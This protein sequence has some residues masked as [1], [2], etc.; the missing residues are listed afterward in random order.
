M[1]SSGL[2]FLIP[3]LFFCQ[4]LCAWEISQYPRAYIDRQFLRSAEEF[5]WRWEKYASDLV[6]SLWD[7]DRSEAEV[8]EEF[9]QLKALRFSIWYTQPEQWVD[10]IEVNEDFL[11]ADQLFFADR[12]RAGNCLAFAYNNT[13][14]IYNSSN[15]I[16]GSDRFLAMEGP[17][18]VLEE[19]FFR[20]LVTYQVS[21]LVRLTPAFETR[22]KCHS[23][24]KGR[25][26]MNDK[27]E[28]TLLV[29]MRGGADYLLRYYEVEN[30][31]D[32]HGMDPE[33]L[34]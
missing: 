5:D 16:I 29:P 11:F 28:T 4:T 8:C 10:Y 33:V 15:I 25:T 32:H 14:P 20:L 31:R 26:K 17:R 27:G 12:F 23:Y 7:P 24:W 9:C 22:K 21:H 1:R 13:H 30:W 34:I 6:F 3:F 19:N 18:S 2:K